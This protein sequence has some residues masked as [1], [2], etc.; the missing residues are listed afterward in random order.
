MSLLRRGHLVGVAPGG[1][2]EAQCGGADTYAT[3]WEGREGF[4]VAAQQAGAPIVPVCM[5]CCHG[6]WQASFYNPLSVW[7]FFTSNIRE[8]VVNLQVGQRRL[9][10]PLLLRRTL[11]SAR[12]VGA[13]PLVP[14]FGAFP[15]KLTTHVGRPLRPED[16][17]VRGGGAAGLKIAAEESIRDLVRRHQVQ[18]Q[19]SNR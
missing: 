4:A 8:S 12:V 10:R 6:K 19:R 16:H 14:L 7:Q 15:V 3:M 18:V 1:G 9:W 5:H 17:V 13:L 11:A 2:R